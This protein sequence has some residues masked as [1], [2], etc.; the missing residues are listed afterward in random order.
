[1]LF[2]KWTMKDPQ[3]PWINEI[4]VVARGGAGSKFVLLLQ[5]FSFPMA[6][7]EFDAKSSKNGIRLQMQL[8]LQKRTSHLVAIVEYTQ[9]V[10]S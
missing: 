9:V 3:L 4:W 10:R 5:P 2:D 6:G 8:L 1:M 7:F